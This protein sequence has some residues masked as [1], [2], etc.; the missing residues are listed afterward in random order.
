MNFE[1]KIKTKYKEVTE[2]TD[3]L[4]K[5]F[6]VRIEQIIYDAVETSKK[7]QSHSKKFDAIDV[8]L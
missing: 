4:S 7:C 1:E 3:V 5:E 2:N 6:E 8:G